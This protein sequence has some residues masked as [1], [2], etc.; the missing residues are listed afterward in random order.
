MIFPREIHEAVPPHY[1]WLIKS[2]NPK[3]LHEALMLYGVYEWR[4]ADN[5]PVIIEWAKEVGRKVGMPYTADSIPWCGLFTAICV[6]RAGFPLPNIAVRAKAWLDWGTPI[7]KSDASRGDVLIFS[8]KGGGHVGF[9]VGEDSECYH[10]LGGN[11][12]DQVN[13]TRIKK[14]RLSG[15]RRCPWRVAQPDSVKPIHLASIGDIS[16][17]EA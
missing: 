16:E 12:S 17:N 4:G 15:I 13:I 8:R 7:D 3:V 1:H 6:K 9:Y 11:Q 14:T 5:N 2:D 10:V